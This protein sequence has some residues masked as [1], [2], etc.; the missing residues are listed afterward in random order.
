[1][2]QN[3]KETIRQQVADMLRM[4]ADGKAKTVATLKH[5]SRSG[6]A[7]IID[8]DIYYTNGDAVEVYNLTDALATL[9]I[10]DLTPPSRPY[11]VKV[12]G[13]GSDMIFEP[14]YRLWLHLE[15]H[16]LM[17]GVEKNKATAYYRR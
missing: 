15:R 12:T 8:Y 10:N 7:R 2:T 9:G 5:V 3:E 13:C 16:G 4:V 11:G 17:D 6:M 14:L 1:M